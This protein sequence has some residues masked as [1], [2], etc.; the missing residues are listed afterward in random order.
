MKIVCI[1]MGDKYGPEYVNVL[2]NMVERNLTVDYEFLCITDNPDGLSCKTLEP[3]PDLPGWWQK[4]ALFKE[5]PYN[6][7]ENMLYIDLDVV[8]I[9]NIDKLTQQKDFTLLQDL[10]LPMYNSSVMFIPHN[11]QTQ[12]WSEFDRESDMASSRCGDQD[13]I[14]KYAKD[15]TTW[16]KNWCLSYRLEARFAASGKLVQF[17]GLPKPHNL[18]HTW[19]GDYWR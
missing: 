2:Q 9:S 13:I 8:I 5:N 19:V 3:D 14:T 17:H 7:R 6:I 18:T 15:A 12:I 11:A 16:P 4:M 10:I 1:K